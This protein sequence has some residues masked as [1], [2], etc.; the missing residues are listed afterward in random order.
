MTQSRLLSVFLVLPWLASAP[1]ALASDGPSDVNGEY[2]AVGAYYEYFVLLPSDGPPEVTFAEESCTGT[3]VSAKVILTAAHCTAF[4]YI[5]DIGIAGYYDQAWVTFDV[6][7]TANDF[8]CFLRDQNVTDGLLVEDQFD[9]LT[10]GSGEGV[11]A[12]A[13]ENGN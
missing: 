11:A 5:Q 1:M 12:F 3:L 7:A 4:N 13:F 10:R 8:R 9:F 6:V 2:P